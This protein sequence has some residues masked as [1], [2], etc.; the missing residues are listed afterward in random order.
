MKCQ[1]LIID[2]IVAEDI[3]IL[4]QSFP[5]L[6]RIVPPFVGSNVRAGVEEPR[7]NNVIKFSYRFGSAL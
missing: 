2:V 1:L 3:E 6:Q 5:I 4:G 7:D